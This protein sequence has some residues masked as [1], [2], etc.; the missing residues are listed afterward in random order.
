MTSL[1]APQP[2]AAEIR[3]TKVRQRA[4]DPIRRP[5]NL[6]QTKLGA[7]VK[8][9]V[10]RPPSF[11][12]AAANDCFRWAGSRNC[13]RAWLSPRLGT[14]RSSWSSRPESDCEC[15]RLRSHDVCCLSQPDYNQSGVLPRHRQRRGSC[16]YRPDHLIRPQCANL[17]WAHPV[18]DLSRASVWQARPSA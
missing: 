2:T 15:K 4:G 3:G 11:A 8:S 16:R 7:L 18:V 12:A 1:L 10:A 9:A 5:R 17:S 13:H 6:L 14:D